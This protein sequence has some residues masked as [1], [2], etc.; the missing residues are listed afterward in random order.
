[1]S[2][3]EAKIITYYHF[4]MT[5]HPLKPNVSVNNLP[6]LVKKSYTNISPLDIEKIKI[7]G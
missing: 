4:S 5:E 1:M 3:T 2:I 6:H 7:R